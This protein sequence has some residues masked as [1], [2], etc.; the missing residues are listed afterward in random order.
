MGIDWQLI[1]TRHPVLAAM[2]ST[3]QLAARLRPFRKGQAL[4]HLG[5]RPTSMLFV[6]AGEVRLVRRTT[7]GSEMI[8]Q[9][10]NTGF[11]AEAS[12]D[13]SAY[14]CD[15]VAASDGQLLLFPRSR[16]KTALAQDAAFNQ[17]WIDLLAAEVR[18][19]R[20]RCERLS[21]NNAADRV[22]HYLEAEGKDG[23]VTLAQTR[24]AW[25]AELGLS[26][27]VLYRTLRA[28]H[29][30]GTIQIDGKRIALQNSKTRSTLKSSR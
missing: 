15:I 29:E 28:L 18:R 3:L 24:K 17:T 25:A 16:F 22:V 20:A 26:H 23:I 12:L 8:L 10:G 1:E 9:R 4:F 2:P 14:H 21:L 13:T 11:I 30:T 5:E 27:E 19:L 6:L 7:A